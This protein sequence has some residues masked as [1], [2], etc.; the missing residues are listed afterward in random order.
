LY[1]CPIIHDIAP[2]FCSKNCMKVLEK[3]IPLKPMRALGELKGVCST[4]FWT[5]FWAA[6]GH[7]SS[8]CP[9]A[10]S[11]LLCVLMAMSLVQKSLHKKK[12]LSGACAAQQKHSILSRKLSHQASYLQNQKVK[13][14]HSNFIRVRCSNNIHF[15]CWHKN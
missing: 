15:F 9:S 2:H 3:H 1:H 12:A 14:P 5:G 10:P 4:W 6:T 13:S 11:K 8:S 7:A